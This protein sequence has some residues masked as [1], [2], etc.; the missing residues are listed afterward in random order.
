MPA[1]GAD[2]SRS[3]EDVKAVFSE[4]F[5][6]LVT[7]LSKAAIGTERAKRK[8]ATRELATMVG[9]ILLARATD[10]DTAKTILKSCAS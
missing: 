4:Q 10:P 8:T 9:A 3:N 5:N 2:V 6:R 7:A 1:L